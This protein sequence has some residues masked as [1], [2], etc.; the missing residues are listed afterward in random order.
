M[1]ALLITLLVLVAVP[2]WAQDDPV[3]EERAELPALP[4]PFGLGWGA[5]MGLSDNFIGDPLVEEG[6]AFI[7]GN[8]IVRVTRFRDVKSRLILESHYTFRLINGSLGVGPVMFVQPGGNL[9]TA[10]GGGLLFELGEGPTSFNLI[11]G[12]LLDFDV[13]RLHPDYI[14]GFEAPTSQLAFVTR[15]ELQF[16]VGFV[17]GR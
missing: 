8:D 10:A 7:D 14:D 6:D 9:F 15:E 3:P 5:G 11:I 2:A 17:I 1:R 4:N 12:G 16:F 13:T